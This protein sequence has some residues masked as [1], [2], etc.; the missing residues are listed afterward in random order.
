MAFINTIPEDK[1]SHQV[2]QMYDEDLAERGYIPNYSRAF[3]HRPQVM[4]A[5]GNLLGSIRN[6]MDTHRYEL[7]TLAAARAL[8]SSYCMLA[9]GSILRKKYYS[10]KQLNLIARDYD[11]A[12][13]TAAEIAMMAYAEQV[14]RDAT[15]I[16][17]DDID[18]LRAHGFSDA[19]IF[20]ITA[21]ATAR[22]FFSK[23]LDALGVE[24]DEIY[25]ELEDGLRQALT[26]GR[27]ISRQAKERNQRNSKR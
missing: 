1:A 18:K 19:E 7:V 9:H 10:S 2:K 6:N 8:R 25:L 4:D 21:T 13:L 24:A 20:D 12:D 26:V 16:T 3:S 11:R 23:I 14:V 22:C 27:P 15:T 5:W 17:Q